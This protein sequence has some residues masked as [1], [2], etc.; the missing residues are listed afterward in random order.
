MAI[1]KTVTVKNGRLPASPGVY[2]MKDRRGKI[3]YI[4]KA[5]SL[6]SRV[7]SYFLRPADERIAMMVTHISSIDYEQTPTAVE[8][9][10]LE[11]KYIKKFQ[12]PYNVEEKDDKSFIH[13]AFTREDF[14]Q[15]VFIRGQELAR[16][17]KRQFL[18]VFGPFQSAAGVKAALDTLRRSFPWT[19]CKSGRKRPCFYRH[20]GL[21][22]GVCTGEISSKDYKKIIRELMRFFA[23]ERAAVIR[24]MKKAMKAA[25]EAE[26]FEQAASLR[27][28]LYALEHIRDMA[29]LKRDDAQIAEFVDIFGRVEGYDISNTSGQDAVGSMVVFVDGQPKPSEY[30]KFRIKLV[31]GP[32]DTAMMEEMLRRRFAHVEQSD[33]DEWPRP[34][35]IMVDGGAGQMNVAKK[36]LD[37]HGLKIPLIG[38]A[39]G[40]DRKQ[41][42]LVYD[43]SDYELGR[44]VQAFKPLLQHLRDEAHRFAIGYHKKLRS[45]TFLKKDIPPA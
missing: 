28:R 40:F 27:D 18:K 5:V 44:L 30:R 32:N 9:L 19:T 24:D 11:A 29:M 39:K 15:P 25:G 36:V 12:P 38:I 2:F 8:A 17:P 26:H 7:G 43:K 16:V 42:Q 10:I 20:L 13:L 33:A 6:R 41:D 35:L 4:G 14:P 21:C 31:E 37:E 34:D 45:K 3:L 22:P 1:P 23:G